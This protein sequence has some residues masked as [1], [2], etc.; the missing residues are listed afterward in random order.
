[1]FLVLGKE[2]GS[3]LLQECSTYPGLRRERLE[4]GVMVAIVMG[5]FGLFL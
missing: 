3:M 1:M 5:S 2:M 4:G